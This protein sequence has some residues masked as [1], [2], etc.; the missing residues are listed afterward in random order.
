MI[1]FKWNVFSLLLE[2]FPKRKGLHFSAV[3]LIGKDEAIQAELMKALEAEHN[4]AEVAE[5]AKSN[6]ANL[7]ARE[8]QA[9]V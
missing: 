3:L 7:S 6:G 9:A 4:A 8:L 5:L 1:G 2:L